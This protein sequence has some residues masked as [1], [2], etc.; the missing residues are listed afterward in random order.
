MITPKELET[1][2]LVSVLC[3]CVHNMRRIFVLLILCPFC[4]IFLVLCVL[5]SVAG[6]SR[7]LHSKNSVL[8]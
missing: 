5:V 2:C 1:V 4:H 7:A 8:I 6:M 3:N